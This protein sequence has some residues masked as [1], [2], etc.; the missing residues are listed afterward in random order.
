M[1]ALQKK[2]VGGNPT[3]SPLAGRRLWQKQQ[4][5]IMG[6]KIKETSHSSIQ[7]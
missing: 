3:G 1:Q 4:G 7:K 6:I 5:Q 2:A